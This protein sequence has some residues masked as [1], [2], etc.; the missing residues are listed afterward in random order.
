M[1]TGRARGC[2]LFHFAPI[3]P[4]K[5]LHA[6]SLARHWFGV[7]NVPIRALINPRPSS[8]C[9]KRGERESKMSVESPRSQSRAT[10]IQRSV[11]KWLSLMFLPSPV[12]F[13]LCFIIP[14]NPPPLPSPL[15]TV[16]FCDPRPLPLPQNVAAKLLVRR[17][18]LPPAS[19]PSP[20]SR[21]WVSFGIASAGRCRDKRQSAVHVPALVLSSRTHQM[22]PRH[23]QDKHW[24]RDQE[25]VYQGK[26]G[27]EK[28]KQIFF[29][30]KFASKS[31]SLFSYNYFILFFNIWLLCRLLWI[32]QK[33][34]IFA[35]WN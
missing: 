14:P 16:L 15:S 21:P 5:T 17:R 23:H 27:A 10:D 6:G 2:F 18:R 9:T 1:K 35:F 29:S 4:S 7:L 25:V 34:N 26:K 13:F 32:I 30:L 12:C 11:Y 31:K 28:E 33:S 22:R 3:N 8:S 20:C 24:A 19:A